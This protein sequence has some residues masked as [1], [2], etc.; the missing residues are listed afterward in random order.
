M[1][2]CTTAGGG[3]GHPFSKGRS[4]WEWPHPVIREGGGLLPQKGEMDGASTLSTL[5][6]C[7]ACE[8]GG[9]SVANKNTVHYGIG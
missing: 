5:K 2:H 9:H 4:R 7:G 8:G 1:I 3:G 6:R